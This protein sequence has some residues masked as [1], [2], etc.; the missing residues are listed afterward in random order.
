MGGSAVRVRAGLDLG[1]ELDKAAA[2]IRGRI[3]IFIK[4]LR[5]D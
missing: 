1:E 3:T 2:L 5:R 4:Q